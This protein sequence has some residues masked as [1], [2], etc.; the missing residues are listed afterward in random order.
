[1]QPQTDKEK[2]T[3]RKTIEPP[4]SWTQFDLFLCV[5]KLNRWGMGR[6]CSHA[7][8]PVTRFFRGGLRWKFMREGSQPAKRGGGMGVSCASVPVFLDNPEFESHF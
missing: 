2:S 1:M 3:V 5:R 7:S 8:S 6:N 4:S